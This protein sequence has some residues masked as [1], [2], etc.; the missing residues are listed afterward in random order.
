MRLAGCGPFVGPATAPRVGNYVHS[1]VHH[2]HGPVLLQYRC[3]MLGT[4]PVCHPPYAAH[5]V[6]WHGGPPLARHHIEAFVAMARRGAADVAWGG[7]CL[8]FVSG[9]APCCSACCDGAALRSGCGAAWCGGRIS[10][11][12]GVAPCCVA[13]CDSALATNVHVKAI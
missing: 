5:Y 6:A 2:V 4:C 9:V 8:S 11:V 12:I 10:S 1:W 7:V 3:D 13:C